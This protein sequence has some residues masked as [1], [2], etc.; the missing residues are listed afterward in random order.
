M[1]PIT[2]ATAV[3]S[4]KG[5]LTGS[6]EQSNVD[7]S[8]QSTGTFEVFTCLC[9]TF[10]ATAQAD[11]LSFVEPGGETFAV[12]FDKDA[13]GTPP[14]GAIYTAAT[15]K[16]EVDIVTGDSAASVA[17]KMKAAIEANVNFDQF[18]I[19]R[20]TA[21]LTFTANKV[22]NATDAAPHTANDGA[23]G[24]LTVSVTTAG[25]AAGTQN[26]YFVL[27]DDDTGLF[28]V[29]CDV[30]SEG[31]DPNPGGGSVGIEV[32][33]AAGATA[34]QVATA[35]AAAVEAHAEFEAEADGARVRITTAT[36]AAVVDIADSNT[37]FTFSVG[38][39]GGA[40]VKPSPATATSSLTNT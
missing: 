22:G 35:V 2:S 27:R 16:I 32:D 31:V 10:A 1:L 26:D 36:N 5:D 13:N 28:H 25:V 3:E 20:D 15:R 11:Y 39:Q 30:N 21:T 33:I 8:G 40:A 4:L 9:A 19:T 12:W 38:T 14:S 7:V 18:A 34:A 17:T 6:P 29:W 37:G 23:A 24:S